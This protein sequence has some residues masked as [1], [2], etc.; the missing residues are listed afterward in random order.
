[1]EIARLLGEALESRDPGRI[2]AALD[3]SGAVSMPDHFSLGGNPEQAVA[4]DI[5]TVRAHTA[6][7]TVGMRRDKGPDKRQ[8]LG[9]I[10]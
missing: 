10:N 2:Q 7:R 9:D 1:M 8:L 3:A 5:N 4:A 6:K